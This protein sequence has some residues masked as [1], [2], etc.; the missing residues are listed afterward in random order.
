M[1]ADTEF[2][3]LATRIFER[4]QAMT[5]GPRKD[6]LAL[7]PYL[8]RNLDYATQRVR[9]AGGSIS[10]NLPI[11]NIC[12]NGIAILAVDEKTPEPDAA[13]HLIFR[14][15]Q[16]VL[17]TLDAQTLPTSQLFAFLAGMTLGRADI[18][19]GQA[20]SGLWDIV[21]EADRNAS[22]ATQALEA[23]RAGGAA[24]G[25]Q[26]AAKAALWK[27]E[28]LE[29]A[30]ILDRELPKRTRGGLATEVLHHLKTKDLPSHKAIEDWL[31]DHAEEPNGPITS[32]RRTR[33]AK[34]SSKAP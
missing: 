19:V 7:T 5:D 30:K 17:A 10:L 32:R 25:A 26:I 33:K 8:V 34:L 23:K 24:R 1:T 4:A 15:T 11:D 20:A 21:Q 16:F 2:A 18:R 9:T 3:E 6:L 13:A 28:A 27:P 22:I 12:A 29:V 14:A 31:K